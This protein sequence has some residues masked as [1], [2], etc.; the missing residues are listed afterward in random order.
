MDLEKKIDKIKDGYTIIEDEQD[1]HDKCGSLYWIW[2]K[3]GWSGRCWELNSEL[4]KDIK[5]AKEEYYKNKDDKDD[6]DDNDDNDDKDD[7]DDKI[8]TKNN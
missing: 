3:N 2:C 1:G 8:E 4:K 5:K 7:K 6:K